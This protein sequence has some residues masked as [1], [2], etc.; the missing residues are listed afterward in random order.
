MQLISI[1]I[2][3][4]I[5]LKELRT[6][7]SVPVNIVVIVI[8]DNP[9]YGYSIQAPAYD[10]LFANLQAKYPVTFRNVNRRLIY[11]AGSFTCYEA[12][13]AMLTVA[14]E[15]SFSIQRSTGLTIVISPGCSLE[16]LVLGD[17][18]RGRLI[19]ISYEKR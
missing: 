1:I 7:G 17:F 9:S 14:G 18:A 6:F 5:L 11:K 15:L 19:K 8:G 10:V 12:G 4:L 13:V 3:L 16:V 2:F